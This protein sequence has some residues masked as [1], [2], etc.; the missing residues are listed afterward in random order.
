MELF[1]V[2]E[3]YIWSHYSEVSW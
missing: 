2:S 1:T 3:N